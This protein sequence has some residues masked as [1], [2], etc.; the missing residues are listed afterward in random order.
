MGDCFIV[1]R[2]GS[3]SG[4]SGLPEFT[5]TGTYQLIDD[6]NGNWRIKFLTSGKLKFTK[7][8][9]AKT[10]IDVFLVGG[11][12]A[13]GYSAGISDWCGPGG[14]GYTKTTN[15]VQ[16]Q[17]GIEYDIIVGAGGTR[18]TVSNTQTQGGQTSAFNTYADGGYSGKSISGGN[19]GSGA[20]S[21]N[22]TLGGTDG[23]DGQK[24][25]NGV[26]EAGKG[27]GTTT[28]E[29]GEASGDLYASGGY[30]GSG[31]GAV[32]TGNGG[33]GTNTNN[34]KTVGGSGIAVVRNHSEAVKIVRQPADLVVSGTEDAE[35]EVIA[36]GRNLTYQW[37]RLS[38]GSNWS[39]TT[40]TGATTSKIT[41]NKYSYSDG[42]KYRCVITDTYGNT[43]TSN[44]ATLT[45]D[46][47]A[48]T[49]QPQDISAAANETVIFTVKASGLN[50]TYQW[51]FCPSAGGDWSNTNATGATTANLMIEAL[52]YRNGYQYRCIVSKGDSQIISD[53]ATLTITA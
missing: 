35:F 13:C 19:G 34:T 9:S 31:D 50:L 39:N 53:A 16:V 33:G 37:Q 12:G 41:V 24:G 38:V 1:R 18:S 43:V 49:Q 8:G 52:S 32:N 21:S 25:A 48:I 29:F 7:L 10:G 30:Y 6:G 11:G 40:V 36:K 42:V 51:Q 26:G 2:G 15:N 46:V 27:Q 17:E 3:V 22:S 44:A 23:G 47:L 14:S 28:R 4:G 45:V 20:A 5:Y